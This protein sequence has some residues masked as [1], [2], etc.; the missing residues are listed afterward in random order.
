MRSPVKAG[1]MALSR[2]HGLQHDWSRSAVIGK[3]LCLVCQIG[4]LTCGA[5]NHEPLILNSQAKLREKRKLRID[6]KNRKEM[7]V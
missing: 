6:H 5:K 4:M 3:T 2:V 1:L 7:V